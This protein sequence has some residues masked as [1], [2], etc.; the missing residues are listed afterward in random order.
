L[1]S[2]RRKASAPTVVADMATV[3]GVLEPVKTSFASALHIE[4]RARQPAA[5]CT[6]VQVWVFGGMR[7]FA[8]LQGRFL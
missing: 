6:K 4:Y 2:W 5:P 7:W 1:N 8:R 3:I